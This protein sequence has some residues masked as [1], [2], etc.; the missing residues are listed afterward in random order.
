MNLPKQAIS[1]L[2]FFSFQFLA[3]ISVDMFQISLSS[4][5]PRRFYI[6]SKFCDVTIQLLCLGDQSSTFLK[7]SYSGRVFL[8]FKEE[9]F[10]S[11]KEKN[12]SVVT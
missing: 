4:Y 12:S 11:F 5:K 6:Q 3:A 1:L 9:M 10:F 7:N 8:I 2:A